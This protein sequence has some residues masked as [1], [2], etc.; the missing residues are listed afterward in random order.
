MLLGHSIAVII[1]RDQNNSF[2]A[3]LF[4]QKDEY[5]FRQHLSVFQCLMNYLHE[6]PHLSPSGGGV[7]SV[8]LTACAIPRT[9]RL[10]LMVLG[11]AQ[12]EHGDTELCG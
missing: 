12:M 1:T 2:S 3:L 8:A 10:Q 6:I 5:I 7:Q 4:V 11:C 9:D